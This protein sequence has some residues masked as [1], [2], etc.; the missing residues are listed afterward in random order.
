MRASAIYVFS[1]VTCTGISVAQEF[2]LARFPEN[3]ASV[4]PALTAALKPYRLSAT[5][6]SSRNN[7]Y[8][9]GGS[10]EIRFNPD[11][12]EKVDRFRSMTFKERATGRIGLGLSMY[13]SFFEKEK[14]ER[15]VSNLSLSSFI[16]L[17]GNHLLSLG[18]Q[19][20]F[21][22]GK[23]Y[24]TTAESHDYQLPSG[25]F[26]E[27]IY[28]DFS[29]GILYRYSRADKRINHTEQTKIQMGASVCHLATPIV[30]YGQTY[31]IPLQYKL[32]A[33]FLQ[34]LGNT[35][36]ALEGFATFL[37]E[38]SQA[39]GG[40]VLRHYTKHDSRYTGINKKSCFG[41][42]LYYR[43]KSLAPAFVLEIKEQYSL[44]IS[45]DMMLSDSDFT[46]PAGLEISFRYTPPK[47]FLY[48]KKAVPRS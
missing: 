41:Y 37:S 24:F 5:Y 14:M 31:S 44:F 20:S 10:I 40:L 46:S 25:F 13:H 18:A 28:P 45:K 47:A 43:N 8:S 42:G 16:P 2:A 30:N 15:M 11:N 32:H 3:P 6:S 38:G 21:V 9:Y 7:D 36:M 34:S 23:R 22:Q 35:N 17:G 29:A 1:L 27:S 39:S 48:E 19:A 4:N 12:W 33:D 26:A